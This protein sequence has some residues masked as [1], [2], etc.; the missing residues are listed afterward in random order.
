MVLIDH[1]PISFPPGTRQAEAAVAGGQAIMIRLA[2]KTTAT[3]TLWADGVTLQVDVEVSSDAGASWRHACG[4][5]FVGG[6]LPGRGEAEASESR[7]T[8]TFQEDV[9][10]TRVTVTIAGGQLNSLLTVESV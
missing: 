9:N 7:L 5:G 6:I 4:G 10:R 1:Q 2:R 8:C 3:P